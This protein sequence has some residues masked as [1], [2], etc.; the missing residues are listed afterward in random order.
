MA[1]HS[2]LPLRGDAASRFDKPITVG[3]DGMLF[4]LPA[5]SHAVERRN[6]F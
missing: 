1:R 4:S 5:G 6:L 3:E 2:D